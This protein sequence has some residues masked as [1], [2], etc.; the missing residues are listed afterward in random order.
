MKAMEDIRS[1]SDV[2]D[3]EELLGVASRRTKSTFK[4]AALS[5]F[6]LLTFCLL[7]FLF[8]V[9]GPFHA[10]WETLGKITLLA[11]AFPFLMTVYFMGMLWTAWSL[12][13][14]AK[15]EF[16]ELLSDRFGVEKI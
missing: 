7:T 2:K 11:T 6:T 13:R 1:D 15:N 16:K 5:V 9:Q 14:D 12:E 8:T 4:C 3:F 10:Y